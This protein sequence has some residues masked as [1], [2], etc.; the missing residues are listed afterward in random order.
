MIN[1][2]TVYEKMTDLKHLHIDT[3]QIWIAFYHFQI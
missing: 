3:S 2:I 1:V